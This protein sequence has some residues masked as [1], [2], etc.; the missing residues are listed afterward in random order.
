VRHVLILLRRHSGKLAATLLLAL[1][2]GVLWWALPVRPRY[3]WALPSQSGIAGF[4]GQGRILQTAGEPSGDSSA[5]FGI[6]LCDIATGE[7]EAAVDCTTEAETLDPLSADA[8]F[9][10]DHDMSSDPWL[11]KIVDV[12]SGKTT[13]RFYCNFKGPPKPAAE[14]CFSPDGKTV[15]CLGAVSKDRAPALHFWEYPTRSIRASLQRPN[16]APLLFSPDGSLLATATYEAGDR[17]RTEEVTIRHSGLVK[18]LN[19]VS[20]RS[21]IDAITLWD[22]ATVRERGRIPV[23][24]QTELVEAIFSA[25]SRTLAIVCRSEGNDNTFQILLWDTVSTSLLSSRAETGKLPTAAP[26]TP[27]EHRYFMHVGKEDLQFCDLKT[28]L[29][30]ALR[31]AQSDSDGQVM[32]FT[33][34]DWGMRECEIA[35]DGKSLAVWREAAGAASF[36]TEWRDKLLSWIGIEPNQTGNLEV[37]DIA[38]RRKLAHFAAQP[39]YAF[40][41]DG[42]LLAVRPDDHTIQIWDIP[43]RKPLGLFLTIA[44]LLIM[45]TLG[46]FWWKARRRKRK[47]AVTTEAILCGTC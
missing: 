2:L 35:P 38:G 33:Q 34:A 3:V 30:T 1:A 26:G 19:V 20:Y 5:N 29:E 10:I 43:P 42:K 37:W 46:G 9:L 45:L 28:G 40:S 7:C 21:G 36:V 13:E 15:A 25:D 41:P 39:D 32:Q 44:G 6:R 8:R 22:A 16:T 12:A 17:L 23:P 18:R 24:P 27:L 4:S 47:A 11:L 14:F 31:I